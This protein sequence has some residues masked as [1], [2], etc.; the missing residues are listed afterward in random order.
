MKNLILTITILIS[1][2][3]VFAQEAQTQ[4]QVT[5]T[6]QTGMV[7]GQRKW[8]VDP[9][10][11][12]ALIF[13]NKYKPDQGQ[14][15]DR[16]GQTIDVVFGYNFGQFEAGPIIRHSH[17]DYETSTETSASYGFF[18]D[19]NFI[20]NKPGV[21][22]VPF[23]RA[24]FAHQLDKDTRNT[25]GLEEETQYDVYSLSAGAKWFPAGDFFAING[26]L[27][28]YQNNAIYTEK[29]SPEFKYTISGPRLKANFAIYF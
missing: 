23:L 13:G 22:I 9:T 6:K 11:I 19:Y 25:N 15:R 20:E 1:G 29:S 17:F 2:S 27:E 4:N 18:G 7:F 24:S 10:S 5:E 21:E 12:V 28:Y 16:N 8:S 14:S 3:L 26:Y